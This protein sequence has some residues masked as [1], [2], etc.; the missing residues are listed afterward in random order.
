MYRSSST[1]DGEFN[2]HLSNL[3]QATAAFHLTY[4]QS[5]RQHIEYAL[6]C[7]TTIQSKAR[8]RVLDF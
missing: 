8:V 7:A 4:G 5:H 3:N 1:T 6:K 2:G